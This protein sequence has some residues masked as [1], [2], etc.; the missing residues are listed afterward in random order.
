M[1]RVGGGGASLGGPG[2]RR[3]G[4]GGGSIGRPCVLGCGPGVPCGGSGV[5][6]GGLG[7][8]VGGVGV[9][10]GGPDVPGGGPTTPSAG[11]RERR[12]GCSLSLCPATVKY[13]RRRDKTK[14]RKMRFLGPPNPLPTTGPTPAHPRRQ[15]PA[16]R[17]ATPSRLARSPR[18][19]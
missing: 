11:G 2:V 8:L 15:S 9:P 6:L 13:R 5:P 4:G 19:C 14:D 17:A 12:S 16:D 7:V 18:I 10:P 3:L 1:P